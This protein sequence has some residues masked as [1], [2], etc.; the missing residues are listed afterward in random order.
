MDFTAILLWGSVSS[1]PSGQVIHAHSHESFFHL[2]YSINGHLTVRVDSQVFPLQPNDILLAGMGRQHELQVNEDT[3]IT[4]ELKFTVPAGDWRDRLNAMT[5]VFTASERAEKWL[6]DLFEEIDKGIRSSSSIEQAML[7]T[8]LLQIITDQTPRDAG[9]QIGTVRPCIAAAIRFIQ[10]NYCRNI[11]LLDIAADCGFNSNYLCTAFKRDTGLSIN[12]YINM[13]RI[14]KAADMILYG[15]MDISHVAS[16]CGFQGP[17]HFSST[18]R[19][20]AGLLPTE[21]RQLFYR[22]IAR[23][24]VFPTHPHHE[25]AIQTPQYIR[26]CEEIARIDGL[27]E[28]S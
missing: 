5:G 28:S 22:S 15:D 17:S 10:E 8:I 3:A 14:H 24:Q 20:Y 25:K 21:C 13:L 18:F 4:G 27:A 12:E 2:F 19:R 9:S 23:L 6:K 26:I 11:R 7:N 1:F 16:I